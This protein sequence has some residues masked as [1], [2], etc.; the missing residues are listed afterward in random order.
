[1]EFI[2]QKQHVVCGRPGAWPT[3]QTRVVVVALHPTDGRSVLQRGDSP[4]WRVDL[5]CWYAVAAARWCGARRWLRTAGGGFRLV[6]QIGTILRKREKRFIT[7]RH[8]QSVD[9]EPSYAEL[10]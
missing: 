4:S 2:W 10:A 6:T 7:V 5:G 8:I 3:H 9:T 1:M